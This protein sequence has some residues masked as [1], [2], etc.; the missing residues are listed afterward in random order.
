MNKLQIFLQNTFDEIAS[1]GLCPICNEPL[2][3]T[4][5]Y[6]YGH[7]VKSDKHFELT[8]FDKDST[9]FDAASFGIILNDIYYLINPFQEY[10]IL[11]NSKTDFSYMPQLNINIS[12]LKDFSI[13][14]I[15]NLINKYNTFQ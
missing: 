8:Y 3:F 5:P 12:D 9:E 2:N 1:S 11:T 15:I 4:Q 14:G 13:N 6:V 10:Y 7:Y